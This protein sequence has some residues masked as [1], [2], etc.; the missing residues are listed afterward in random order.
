M[1]KEEYTRDD[2]KA[3]EGSPVPKAKKRVRDDN[4]T[5]HIPS[6]ASTGFVSDLLTKGSKRAKIPSAVDFER[7][8]EDEDLETEAGHRIQDRRLHL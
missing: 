7:A 1:E 4:A 3:K 8:G 2:P 5:R 6:G